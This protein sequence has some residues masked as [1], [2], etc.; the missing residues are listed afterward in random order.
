MCS[1]H[2]L[3]CRPV[4]ERAAAPAVAISGADVPEVLEKAEEAEV[5]QQAEEAEVPER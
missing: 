5:L 2:S 3:C 4:Q 1:M